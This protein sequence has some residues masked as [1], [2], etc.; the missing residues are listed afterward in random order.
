[1]AVGTLAVV[2]FGA[3]A[4]GALARP[5]M[6][7]ARLT[8]AMSATYDASGYTSATSN[9]PGE[10]SVVNAPDLYET[11]VGGSVTQ[12][13]AGNDIYD[14]VPAA[15]GPGAR[16]VE[17]VPQGSASA[18]FAGFGGDDVT[19]AGATYTVSRHG[20]ELG[21]YVVRN[22]YVV[23]TT[24]SYRSIPG[25]GSASVTETFRS[26]GHAPRIVV[27][28]PNEVIVAPQLYA[29]GCPL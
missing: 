7:A 15:C 27:P 14:A 13:W 24:L 22:G 6:A 28:T 12:V 1:L 23:S 19:E 16:F 17:T 2:A 26:I 29:H 9:D 5:D 18:Q 25:A 20:V 4:F 3:A 10:E 21:R 8:A 11:I